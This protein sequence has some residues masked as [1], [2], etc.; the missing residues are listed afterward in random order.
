MLLTHKSRA[1][2]NLDL[3]CCRNA[4]R[5]AV[6]FPPCPI[7]EEEKFEFSQCSKQ[8][9]RVRNEEN[10]PLC[11]RSDGAELAFGED[12]IPS[13]GGEEE[14]EMAGSRGPDEIC[15]SLHPGRKDTFLNPSIQAEAEATSRG[16]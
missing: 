9:R 7:S 4:H 14:A 16:K 1:M 3:M 11:G 13:G 12:V 15:S 8:I 10:S 5:R 2:E 6:L